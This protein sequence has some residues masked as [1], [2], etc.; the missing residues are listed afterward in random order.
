MNNVQIALNSIDWD[1]KIE[2]EN[3]DKILHT[4]IEEWPYDWCDIAIKEKWYE[5]TDQ[6]NYEQLRHDYK[7]NNGKETQEFLGDSVFKNWWNI[8]LDI[9][10]DDVDLDK[11]NRVSFECYF[12][13]NKDENEFK[14]IL[15]LEQFDLSVQKFSHTYQQKNIIFDKLVIG[16]VGFFIPKKFRKQ[17]FSKLLTQHL[18]N[19]YEPFINDIKQEENKKFIPIIIAYEKGKIVLNKSKAPFIIIDESQEGNSQNEKISKQILSDLEK[20][21]SVIKYWDSNITIQKQSKNL[22]FK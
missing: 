2:L 22:T 21:N 8:G 10:S 19:D 15:V 1:T 9:I 6:K 4:I 3:G 13:T 16:K 12:L 20:E 17:G 18:I 7:I 5:S 11:N 14:G